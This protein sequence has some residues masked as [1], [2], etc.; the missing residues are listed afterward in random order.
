MKAISIINKSHPTCDIQRNNVLLLFC[1]CYNR[2]G[3]IMGMIV[4][5]IVIELT[6]F[7]DLTNIGCDVH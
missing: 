1:P 2:E 7:I 4:N 6:T 3:T 5:W